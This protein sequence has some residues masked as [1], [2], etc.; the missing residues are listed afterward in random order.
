MATENLRLTGIEAIGD[1]PWG[2]HFCYFYL[3]KKDL[4]NL[5]IPYFKEGLFNNE[6]CIWITSNGLEE[7][8]AEDLLEKEVPNIKEYISKG[9]MEII[10][11]KNFFYKD[12][13]LNLDNV[14]KLWL[15]KH[16]LAITRGYDGIRITSDFRW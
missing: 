2:S 11:Y 9:Q 4:L 3:E 10:H 7:E 16:D 12:N 5:L 15:E 1:I 13:E 6:Y 14:I 8:E